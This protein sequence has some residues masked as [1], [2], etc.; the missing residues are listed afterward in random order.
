M[1]ILYFSMLYRHIPVCSQ[2]C[3]NNW[4]NKY[5][6]W[7]AIILAKQENHTVWLPPTERKWLNIQQQF[8]QGRRTEKSGRLRPSTLYNQNI[9][10]KTLTVKGDGCFSTQ[11][12]FSFFPISILKAFL[13]CNKT[14]FYPSGYVTSIWQ[15]ILRTLEIYTPI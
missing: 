2:D 5:C 15:M 7:I 13:I 4:I 11:M 14:E 10:S 1:V 12:V 8:S 3:Y 6:I 9:Q